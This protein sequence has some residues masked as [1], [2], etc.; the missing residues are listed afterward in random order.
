MRKLL[1]IAFV[2]VM[3][4]S[5]KKGELGSVSFNVKQN[6]TF[7]IPANNGILDLLEVL[8]PAMS[9]NWNGEFQNNNTNADNLREMKLKAASMT[10]TEPAGQTW[11]FLEKIE[12]YLKADGLDE[13]KIAYKENIDPNIGQTLNLDVVDVDLKPYAKKDA[14]QLRIK[15]KA[16]E[17]TSQPTKG[18]FELTFGVTA[19]VLG[20]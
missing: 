7:E 12:V 15:T 18:T 8:T 11:K 19:N 4:S 10:I 13:V 16:R 9:S 3:A 1:L 6:G 14:I 2:A 17:Q 20:E 5:C